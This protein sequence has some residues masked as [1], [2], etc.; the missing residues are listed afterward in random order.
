MEA[1]PLLRSSGENDLKGK[2]LLML[3][4]VVVWGNHSKRLSSISYH[5]EIDPCLF[6]AVPR[7]CT[8]I[9]CFVVIASRFP[10]GTPLLEPS[11]LGG[12]MKLML[13]FATLRSFEQSGSVK[14]LCICYGRL[15]T[16]PTCVFQ[17]QVSQAVLREPS[18]RR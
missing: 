18:L 4:V 10:T 16:N 7:T 9:T 6:L 1:F 2:D 13:I 3:G 14:S 12:K 17:R 8:L 15:S 5:I 11:Q